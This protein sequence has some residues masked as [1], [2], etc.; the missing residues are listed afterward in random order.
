MNLM[1]WFRKNNRKV[2]AVVIIII[3]FGFIGGEFFRQLGQRRA[4]LH[5]TIAYFGESKKIT[6]NDRVWAQ[7]ELGI[8]KSLG[9]DILL[10][11]VQTSLFRQ[12]DLRA[13][14][15]GELLFSERGISPQLI[16]KIKQTIIANR[17]RISDKQI[18]N[19]YRGPVSS[20]IYWLLLKKEAEQAGIRVSKEEAG[21]LLGRAIPSLFNGTSY[22]QL[23]E[24]MVSR[25]GIPESKILEAFG[26]LL[27]VSEYAKMMCSTQ[28]I[29]KSQIMHSVSWDNERFDVEFVKMDSAVFADTQDE[30]SEEEMVE[31][32]E[33]YKKFFAGEISDQNP[34]GFGY[35]LAD[36][37]KLEYIAVKFEDVSKTVATPTQQ[38]K[39][40]YYQRHSQQMT[41]QVPLDP[42]D[43]NSPMIERTRS[44]GEV[45]SEIS[46]IL[47]Q[48][49]INS[50]VEQIIQ[51]A[52][53]LTEVGFEEVLT[54]TLS[55]E[56]FRQAALAGDYKTAAE[57]LAEKYNITVYSGQT[58]LLS[59]NDMHA[60]ELFSRLYLRSYGYNPVGLYLIIFAIDQLNSSELGLFDIS[61]PRMYENLG[62]VR[63]IS[64]LMQ[65]TDISG[66]IMALA[67]VIEAQKA[68]EPDNI[69]YTYRRDTLKIDQEQDI[70]AVYSVKDQVIAD[71][72]K[73]AAMD[74]TKSK[75]GEFITAVDTSGWNSTIIDFNKLYGQQTT[76][77]E[78]SPKIFRLQNLTN[79]QRIPTSVSNTW[80]AQSRGDPTA[81][82]IINNGEK[83][84][85]LRDQ[86]YSLV[87]QDA[88]TIEN[89]PVTMEFK[90]DMC[91]YCIKNISVKR[92]N[93]QQYEA[94]K[95]L[96]GYKEDVVEA[97]SLAVIHF[98][99]ENILK[100][101]N[102]KVINEN[103]EP[104]DVNT[105]E[106][107][108]EI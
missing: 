22:S 64:E 16:N 17:Y 97:Q 63:D 69:N 4:G 50:K 51:E 44:Y 87:P 72:K 100:R 55:A 29:T 80:I 60:D 11:N 41:K 79:L 104:V 92:L 57:K 54:D 7:Q 96:Q 47:L 27:A 24:T 102:F 25:Q 94:T 61:K 30:P 43:P 88:N 26:K 31:H 35:K 39:E 56:Q 68:A 93:Q 14:L 40:E 3:L 89:L 8:L 71:L 33:M 78:N 82:S 20:D 84:R 103:G 15:L 77:N 98:A 37:V 38:E 45:A 65:P 1:K 10:K 76:Q 18:S 62:P 9:A 42:N 108:D 81:Q 107:T 90:P 58:G 86:F 6:N 28:N 105:P 21:N 73:L 19:V 49:K 53:T 74:T 91:Y 106:P 66:R 2:M 99:P 5:K 85:Q 46:K 83:E 32:F 36:R 67:R 34:Y 13:F 95:T 101:M 12:P 23:I 75:A 59:A 70:E 52:K 48:N